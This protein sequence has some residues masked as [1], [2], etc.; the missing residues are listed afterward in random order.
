MSPFLQSF[1]TAAIT[2]PLAA[3]LTA[4]FALHRFYRER[5]WERKAAAYSAIFEALHDM[6]QWYDRH[7]EAEIEGRE[8]P[9]DEQIRLRESYRNAKVG[10]GRR[11]DAE[12]WLLS[13]VCFHHLE[14]M[15]QELEKHR[16]AFF[17]E[18]DEGL[19]ATRKAIEE[20][21]SIAQHDLGLAPPAWQTWRRQRLK[22]GKHG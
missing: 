8:I 5:I 3:W 2:A 12:R 14:Q 10:L 17:E 6:R 21:P 11:L 7:M 1:L 4:R 15:N 13:P 18:L 9:E 16:D 22:A 20:M 19:Y